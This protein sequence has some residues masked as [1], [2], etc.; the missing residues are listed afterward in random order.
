MCSA[1]TPDCGYDKNTITFIGDV[2]CPNTK[3]LDKFCPHKKMFQCLGRYNYQ[4]ARLCAWCSIFYLKIKQMLFLS[5]GLGVYIF[6]ESQKSIQD[7]IGDIYCPGKYCFNREK[8]E[9]LECYL[10]SPRSI[11]G[12]GKCGAWL[13]IQ[14]VPFMLQEHVKTTKTD[15]TRFF[16]VKKRLTWYHPT[17]NCYL[18]PHFN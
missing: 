12:C 13:F 16:F 5:I 15:T 4:C 8:C 14:K 2:Y 17:N 9:S 10:T 1:F 11:Y 3:N 18:M 6:G 7:A